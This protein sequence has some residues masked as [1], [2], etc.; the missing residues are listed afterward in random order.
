MGVLAPRVTRRAVAA[1]GGR[2]TGFKPVS[3]SEKGTVVVPESYPAE[4]FVAW[5]EPVGVTG[6]MPAFRRDAGNSAADQAVQARSLRVV[7]DL[8]RSLPRR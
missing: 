2:L 3:V 6:N 5:V 1:C 4:S 7:P 8:G